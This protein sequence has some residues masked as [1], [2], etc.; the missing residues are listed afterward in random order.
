[1][2]K[3]NRYARCQSAYPGHFRLSLKRCCR[4]CCLVCINAV[5]NPNNT[6][7]FTHLNDTT[8]FIESNSDFIAGSDSMSRSLGTPDK[9]IFRLHDLPLELVQRIIHECFLVRGLGRGMRLRLVNRG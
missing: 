2:A 4:S 8:T 9:V 5:S 3:M 6:F 1:M 7:A